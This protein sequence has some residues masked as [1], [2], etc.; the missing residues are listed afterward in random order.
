MHGKTLLGLA[1]AAAFAI[2]QLAH[3]ADMPLKAPIMK[4]P[5]PAFSWSGCYIGGNVGGKSVYRGPVLRHS[6]E[7]I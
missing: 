5:P 4:A 2:P 7:L 6:A 1:A 3:A